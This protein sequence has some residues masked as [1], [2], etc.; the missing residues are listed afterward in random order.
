M[1]GFGGVGGGGGEQGGKDGQDGGR[2]TCGTGGAH[3]IPSRRSRIGRDLRSGAGRRHARRPAP[4]TRA[5][6]KSHKRVGPPCSRCSPWPWPA[7]VPSAR[8]VQLWPHPWRCRSRGSSSERSPRRPVCSPSRSAAGPLEPA[9]RDLLHAVGDDA[10]NRA[11]LSFGGDG[12]TR[13]AAEIELQCATVVGRHGRLD[14]LVVDYLG[15]MNGALQQR[16][17]GDRQEEVAMVVADLQELATRLD[18]AVVI[19]EQL[20][21]APELRDDTGPGS[22]TS[23]MAKPC[24]AARKRS[25]CC[26]GPRTTTPS[27][28][29][30]AT[31]GRPIP[32]STRR[33]CSCGT[34]YPSP[35]SSAPS[36]SCR[37]TATAGP[38]PALSS[39]AGC[40]RSSRG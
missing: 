21:R 15:L 25:S 29:R 38:G 4:L 24:S 18:A 23:A 33:N 11:L 32:S 40:S 10:G 31:T 22:T 27:T 16:A 6:G 5:G 12:T 35:P 34:D 39:V 17:S 37:T 3:Q 19:V 2:G 14:L 8:A 7:T 26:T 1:R 13:S 28:A 30:A 9:E 20:T 36:S